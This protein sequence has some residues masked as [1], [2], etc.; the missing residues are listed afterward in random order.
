MLKA[1][2]TLTAQF[3]QYK[4]NVPAHPGQC[5]L[6]PAAAVNRADFIVGFCGQTEEE[7]PA[8]D[9]HCSVGRGLRTCYIF[10]YLNA[11]R[12]KAA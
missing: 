1:D 5:S 3:E 7:F 9:R 4:E 10:K 8:V 12:P 2:E 6:T 11:T